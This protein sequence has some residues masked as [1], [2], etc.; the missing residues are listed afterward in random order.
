M[1]MLHVSVTGRVQGVGYRWFVREQARALGLRGW[2]INRADESV[3]VVAAG[4][5]EDVAA[6]RQAIS[7][8]PTGAHVVQVVELPPLASPNLPRE[9]S[10]RG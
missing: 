7:R 2:V 4:A 5:A 9:F 1:P 6:M 10:I 3:E 8:G